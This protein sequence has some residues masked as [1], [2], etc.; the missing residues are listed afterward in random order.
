[1][2]GDLVMSDIVCI[3]KTSTITTGSCKV[4][5]ILIEDTIYNF[6]E[7]KL[8]QIDWSTFK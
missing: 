4:K 6:K 1:M 8:Y 5:S 2:I 3:S 7:K